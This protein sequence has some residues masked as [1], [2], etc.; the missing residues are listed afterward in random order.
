MAR[1]VQLTRTQ[2]V[3]NRFCRFISAYFIFLTFPLASHSRLANLLFSY[4][5]FDYFFDAHCMLSRNAFI[6]RS[7]DTQMAFLLLTAMPSDDL[8]CSSHFTV[9]EKP[10]WQNIEMKISMGTWCITIAVCHLLS[11]QLDENNDV[12]SFIYWPTINLK[13]SYR[14]LNIDTRCV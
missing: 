3:P 2:T 12:I 9:N 6:C 5:T 14:L 8:S 10:N 1:D 13:T 4:L 7:D 11:S